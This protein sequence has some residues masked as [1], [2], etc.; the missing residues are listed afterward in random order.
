MIASGG[1]GI[2]LAAVIQVACILG[3]ALL[4]FVSRSEGENGG[5]ASYGLL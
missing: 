5:D 2:G 4:F 1:G 3:G